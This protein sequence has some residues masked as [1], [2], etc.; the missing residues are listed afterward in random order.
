MI[1][2]SDVQAGDVLQV[3]AVDLPCLH[4]GDLV[5]V[6]EDSPGFL[7]CR[8]MWG[9]HSLQRLGDQDRQLPFVKTNLSERHASDLVIDRWCPK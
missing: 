6:R 1:K 8:C 3:T 5:L 7:H 9:I 2:S 4:P